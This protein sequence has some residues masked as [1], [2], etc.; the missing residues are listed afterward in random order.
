MT[1]FITG[2]AGFIGSQ[3]TDRLLANGET[4][5]GYDNLSTGE[6][7]FLEQASANPNFRFIKGD[8]LDAETLTRAMNGREFR[9]PSRR[10]CRRAFRH[11]TSA[12]ATSSRTPSRPSTC[13]R[14]C[15][16]TACKRIGFSSTGSIYGEPD[17]FPTPED[18]PFPVQTSLYG[19][20]KLAGEGMIQ[21]YCEGFGFQ[22]CIFRFVSI[23]GE[24]Y[25][26]GHVF[27]FFKKLSDDPS[28]LHVLGNG[29]QRKSYLYVQDCI[30]AMLLAIRVPTTRS[31]SS[32]SAPTKQAA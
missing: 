6:M 16:R 20:S 4:V 22:A 24:R 18:A 3:L 25:T 27:D 2:A 17:D 13:S 12:S 11:R 31:T 28:S 8:L 26:H 7:R 9:L 15:G 21:A 32:I 19:A 29:Q 5:V 23:L 1:Y 14:P 10:Q 30:D